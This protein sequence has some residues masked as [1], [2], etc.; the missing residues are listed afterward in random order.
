MSKVVIF[1][2]GSF[3]ETVHFYLTHDSEHEVVA[4]TVH[5]KQLSAKQF[6]GITIVPFEQ[7]ENDFPPESFEMYIAVGYR[8][9]N[10]LRASIYTEAK[11]KGYRLVSY[12]SSKCTYWGETIGD[13]CF[14]FEDN[15]IQPF[16]SIG[17]NVILWSGNHIGHHSS[18]G[19]HCFI[20]SHVVI[21]GNCKIGDYTFIGVNSTLRDNISVGKSCLIG[22]GSIIMKDAKNNELYIAKRTFPD[23]R[24]T[25]EINF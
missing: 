13:N 12:I 7:I 22:A 11:R 5:E 16:V 18:I 4:F 1:G 3:A 19:D 17:N 24:S 8:K 20:S 9:L 21:S 2:T 14:V 10:K 15:T 6:K 25:D 23:A